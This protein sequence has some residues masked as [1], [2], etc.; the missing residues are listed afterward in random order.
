M[1]LGLYVSRCGGRVDDVVDI[2]EALSDARETAAVVRVVDDFHD[3]ETIERMAAD[4]RDAE[5]DAVVLAG[6]SVTYYATSLS[7]QQTRA[8][9]VE[10]GLNPN[11]VVVANIL[12]Q[13]ALPHAD[14]PAGATA[15]AKALIDVGVLRATIA[16]P[17]EGIPTEPRASVLIL[18]ATPEGLIAAQRLLQFGFSVVIV[19]R[20][21]RLREARPESLEATASFVLGHPGATVVRGGPLVDA[22]GWAGDFEVTLDGEDGRST[23][24]AGGILIADSS[25]QAWLGELK[26]HFRVD[27]DDDGHARTIDPATH[28]VE[29]VEPGIMVVSTREDQGRVRDAVTAADSS[30]IALMLLLSQE[31]IVHYRD[32]SV[33]DEGLCGGCASCVRTCAFG[34]CYLGEDGFAGVDVRRCR[35]CGKCVVSCPVGARD[36]VNSPHRYLVDAIHRLA[37]TE[38]P[39]STRVLGFL[40]GGCGYPAADQGASECVESSYPASFLPLRIPCGGRLDTLYVLE[41]FKSGFDSVT[42]FRCREGHCHNLIGNL[43]MDRRMNLLRAVLRSRRIDNSRLRIIDISPFDGE[44]FVEQVNEVFTSLNTLD[45]AEEVA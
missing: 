15:K 22:Q 18:G 5:L 19:D 40:C 32:T 42:V 44:R 27:T 26:P 20:D 16:E 9:L 23:F 33:V 31:E 29:T 4:V 37:Q 25:D 36:I 28:P 3:S 17:L 13:V 39:D 41:A 6:P 38:T 11:R 30:A 21:E 45:E 7:G 35:G 14:D 34:A 1:P 2:D 8:R 10:A 12:E 43:D 24:R